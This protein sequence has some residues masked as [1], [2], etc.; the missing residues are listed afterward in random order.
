MKTF[1]VLIIGAGRIGASFDTPTN[2]GLSNFSRFLSYL[3]S[4]PP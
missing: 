1:S 2:A 3:T 4:K